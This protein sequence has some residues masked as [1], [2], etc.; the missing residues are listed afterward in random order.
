M[1][2]GDKSRK[3]KR[4]EIELSSANRARKLTRSMCYIILWKVNGRSNLQRRGWFPVFVPEWVWRVR[5]QPF[6][7]LWTE[8]F[9]HRQLGQTTESGYKP[10]VTDLLG[11]VSFIEIPYP[12]I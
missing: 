5:H 1:F 8:Q 10:A 2:P 12:S 9:H 3:I 4:I 6:R 11:L 7:G